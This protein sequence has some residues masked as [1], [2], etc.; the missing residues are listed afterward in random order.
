MALPTKIFLN[1][2]KKKKRKQEYQCT[3]NTES[4]KFIG[5]LADGEVAQFR[6]GQWNDPSWS[7]RRPLL[8]S[9]DTISQITRRS[10]AILSRERSHRLFRGSLIDLRASFLRSSSICDLE[11]LS[12]RSSRFSKRKW[13]NCARS[14]GGCRCN[15]RFTVSNV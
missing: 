10:P 8:V 7:D 2:S 15:Y 9:S 11:R 6:A 13:A 1:K 12:R 3:I 4:S 5:R 14:I